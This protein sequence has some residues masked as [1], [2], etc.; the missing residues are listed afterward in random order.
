MEIST[1]SSNYSRLLPANHLLE[2]ADELIIE[3][4]VEDEVEG[5]VADEQH[6]GDAAEYFVERG[7]Q[8][9]PQCVAS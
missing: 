9:L 4:G 1:R 8:E 6:V 5:H 3:G 2:D 7:V